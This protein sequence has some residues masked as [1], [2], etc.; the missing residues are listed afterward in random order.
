V[1]QYRLALIGAAKRD[2]TYPARAVDRGWEGRV[3]I[4]LVIGSDG[5]LAR[6]LVQRSSGHDVLD[7]QTLE[8]FRAAHAVTPVP[9]ALRNREFAVEVAVRYELKDGR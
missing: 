7:R 5:E 8:M 9:S 1:A 4:R 2:K 6:A 3:E